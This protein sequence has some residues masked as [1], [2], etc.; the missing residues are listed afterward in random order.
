MSVTE[1]VNVIANKNLELKESEFSIINVYAHSACS[2]SY[3][4]LH[5]LLLSLL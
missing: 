5:E 4:S 3:I 1:S 2:I